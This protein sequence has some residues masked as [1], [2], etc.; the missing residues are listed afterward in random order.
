MEYSGDNIIGSSVVIYGSY[1]IAS[2]RHHTIPWYQYC[3]I[4]LW[5]WYYWSSIAIWLLYSHLYQ[6]VMCDIVDIPYHT[7]MPVLHDIIADIIRCNMAPILPSLPPTVRNCAQTRCNHKRWLSLK[8]FLE[9]WS[10]DFIGDWCSWCC[11]GW[12]GPGLASRVNR[13]LL[14]YPREVTLSI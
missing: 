3:R 1:F 14:F 6:D 11:W 8:C 5:L 10:L 9:I 13:F 4:L 12:C 2:A 7:M